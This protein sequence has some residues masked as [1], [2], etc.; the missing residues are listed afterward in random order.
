MCLG[1]NPL[2]QS[3]QPYISAETWLSQLDENGILIMKHANDHGPS[4]ASGMDPSGVKYQ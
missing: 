4:G 3:C 2:D 1:A